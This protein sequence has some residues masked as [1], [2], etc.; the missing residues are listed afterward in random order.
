MAQL[1]H[2][3]I[4]DIHDFGRD[5]G[6]VFAVT[7]LLEGQ[8][9]RRRLRGASLPLSK[10]IEIGI[11]VATGLAAAH[12]KNVVHR[13]VK[14]ENVFITSAGH[15]KILDFGIAGLRDT[16]PAG[17]VDIDARTESLTATGS[18]VGTAGYMSTLAATSSPSVV[19]STRC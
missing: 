14:P 12:G 4:L 11:A 10:A 7:E 13:D 5:D 18:V 3:N 19:C 6:I 1:S 8:D 9:L 17:N 16:L 15:V 2:P